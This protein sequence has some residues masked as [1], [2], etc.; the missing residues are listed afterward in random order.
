MEPVTG[1]A[2]VTGTSRDEPEEGS[3]PTVLVLSDEQAAMI[4]EYAA[5]LPKIEGPEKKPAEYGEY[6]SSRWARSKRKRPGKK[7]KRQ[8][9][10]HRERRPRKIMEPPAM[11]VPPLS[12]MRTVMEP[13]KVRRSLQ[14]GGGIIEEKEN[15]SARGSVEVALRPVAREA[16]GTT[17]DH[18]VAEVINTG[19]AR[20]PGCWASLH[21]KLPEGLVQLQDPPL[22]LYVRRAL[23]LVSV[24]IQPA[25]PVVNQ[26][27]WPS[28][29]A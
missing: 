8:T 29:L 9:K 23:P 12:P 1:H 27:N 25:E 20:G 4:V 10:P 16:A 2:G 19:F 11:Y 7:A 6:P 15:I 14:S 13:G 18:A 21:D 22:V 3:P 28:S 17:G 24:R 26:S 5:S